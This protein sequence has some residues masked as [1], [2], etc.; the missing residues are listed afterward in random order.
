MK[1]LPGNRVL[2][3]QEYVYNLQ[4]FSGFDI[5][6]TKGSIGV[7]MSIE[8]IVADWNSQENP[9]PYYNPARIK[10]WM[11]KGEKYPIRLL[12]VEPYTGDTS[13]LYENRCIVGEI[14]IYDANPN[15]MRVI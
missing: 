3:T 14:Q 9:N 7:V 5:W 13:G 10:N 11:D 8:E 15:F 4:D 12:S 1:L 6:A 2:F